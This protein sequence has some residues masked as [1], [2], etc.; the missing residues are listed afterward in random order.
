M[1]S[2][3]PAAPRLHPQ[4]RWWALSFGWWTLNG[5]A[6]ATFYRRMRDATGAQP[7]WGRSLAVTL[8]SA[9]IWVPI[10]V[11][12]IWLAGRYPLGR[13]LW[14]RHLPVHLAATAAVIL[15]RALV[16][17]AANRWIGWYEDGLPAFGEVLI[18]SVENNLFFYW[19]V[20]G[21]A[22]DVHFAGRDRV[23]ERQLAEARMQALK[24]QIHPHFLFNTLNTI[25]SFVH[26][27]P[28]TAERMVARLSDLL[29]H[30][31]A[32]SRENE[33]PLEEELEFLEPYLEIEQ[34][35]F[36]DRLRV[37]WAVEPE[38]R[39]ARV[40]HLVLQPLVENA[41][42]HGLGRRAA[43]GTVEIG[44]ARLGD[45]LRLTVRDDGA[46]LPADFA[47]RPARGMGVANVRARLAQ[48]Y[49]DAHRFELTPA[50]GGGVTALIEIPF[51]RFTEPAGTVE[52][53]EEDG[54]EALPPSP[55]LV[56]SNV[57]DRR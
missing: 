30:T 14:R 42:R 55:V 11:G 46:G 7:S 23:R 33:V 48:L 40:P 54:V 41:L 20:T 47:R 5:F 49:G 13:G 24:A 31:L 51:R 25:S 29:R 3:A 15:L 57:G 6:S 45:R 27:D 19:M 28:D 37:R 2:Q 52:G 8:A 43:A 35:R 50:E 39:E 1:D 32:A 36:E 18:T 26:H 53:R 4:W 10:T 34:A 22:H 9:W 56:P 17:V 12:A 44:A 21:V 16:V 38:T